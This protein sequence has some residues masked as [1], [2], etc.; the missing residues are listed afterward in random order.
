MRHISRK[1]AYKLEELSKDCN[2]DK[3]DWVIV[4][5]PKMKNDIRCGKCGMNQEWFKEHFN[6][7]C[8]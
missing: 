1:E 6:Q 7:P 4:D 8:K 2:Y 3:H 5:N